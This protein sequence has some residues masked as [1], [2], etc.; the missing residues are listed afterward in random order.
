MPR[1]CR[2]DPRIKTIDRGFVS[3]FVPRRLNFV[4]NFVTWRVGEGNFVTNLR[5]RVGHG[6]AGSGYYL[7]V[8]VFPRLRPALPGPHRH[9]GLMRQT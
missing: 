8:D 6:V 3:H 7:W 9:Y 2:D 5:Q 1:G 4:T